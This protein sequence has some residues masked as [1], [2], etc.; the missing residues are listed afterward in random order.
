MAKQVGKRI[1]YFRERARDE[2]GRKLTA[3]ALAD[4]CTELGLPIGRPAIAKMERGL[5]DTITVTGAGSDRARPE[6][7]P[8]DLMFPLGQ[9][10][11][12][13]LMPGEHM[14]TW[15]AVLW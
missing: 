14:D 5:R 4:K 10:E 12:V 3:K 11:T 7:V 9:R 13:E 1:A 6:R 8:A 15:E 2:R